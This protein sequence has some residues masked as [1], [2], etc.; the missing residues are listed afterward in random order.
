MVAFSE[1]VGKFIAS[2]LLVISIFSFIVITQND[3]DTEI[4][5]I[6]NSTIFNQSFNLLNTKIENSTQSA[7]EKY[8]SFNSEDPQPGFGSIV[9]FGIVSVGKSFSEIIFGFFSA[10]IKLPLAVLGIPEGIYNLIITWLII[11]VIVGVWL[12]YKYGG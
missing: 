1:T 9:L 4:K 10:I 6:E 5:M 3:N 8:D 2:A 11:I 7:Q 12:L